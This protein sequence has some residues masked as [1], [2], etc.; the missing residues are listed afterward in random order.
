MKLFVVLLLMLCLLT[1]LVNADASPG[2]GSSMTPDEA[3]ERATAVFAGRVSTITRLYGPRGRLGAEGVPYDE[4]KFEVE[5]S[6]KL[7]D[8]REIT[9]V[10]QNIYPGTCGNFSTGETYL[11]YADRLNDVF[12]VSALSRTNRLA[13]AEQD[14]KVL[15][16]ARVQLY[17][18]QFRTY[19]IIVYGTLV[20]VLFALL[21]GISLYRLNKKP[22]RAI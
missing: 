8:R 21:V 13:D 22:F 5:Q 2:C 11:V 9:I 14:L 6:W 16:E 12:F 20:C 1:F 19:K 18:G 15:G 3:Y 10:S 17:S 4:V 7:I